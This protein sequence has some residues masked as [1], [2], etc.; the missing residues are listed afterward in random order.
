MAIWDIDTASNYLHASSQGV[1]Y[2]AGKGQ[3]PARNVAGQWYFVD[4]TLQPFQNAEIL[5]PYLK[6]AVPQ[7]HV[8][9]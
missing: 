3:L 4:T 6:E 7:D 5:Q 9:P 1:R 2:L 8:D